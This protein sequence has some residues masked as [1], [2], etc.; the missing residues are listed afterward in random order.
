MAVLADVNYT[1]GAKL[2][3]LQEAAHAHNIE[4]SIHRVANGEEIAAAIDR[5]QASGATALNIVASPLFY[6][7]RHLIMERVAALHLPTIYQ[8]PERRRK[9]ALPPT[10]RAGVNCCQ[11]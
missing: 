6:A 8:W 1:T 7:H 9:A 10:G 3:A 11:K 4:L 2:D 5:A